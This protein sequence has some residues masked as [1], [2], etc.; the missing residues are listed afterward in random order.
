MTEEEILSMQPGRELDALIAE[1][2]MGWHTFSPV[3]PKCDH[4]V[5]ANG[6]RRNFA[7]DPKDDKYKPFPLFS[8]EI[9]ATIE[10]AEKL[11][12]K[13]HYNISKDIRFGDYWVTFENEDNVYSSPGDAIPE[14][15][16]KAALLAAWE[17]KGA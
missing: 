3:D 14:A 8:T 6:K 9:S 1:K 2:V 12:Q 7:F 4:S 10:V 5:S 16:C 11:S 17:L 15:I 13:Y